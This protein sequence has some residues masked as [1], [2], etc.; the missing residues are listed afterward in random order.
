MLSLLDCIKLEFLLLGK[1]PAN[2]Y[3]GKYKNEN[4]LSFYPTDT[5][6]NPFMR[7]ADYYKLIAN[8][9]FRMWLINE[10]ELIENNL[11][12]IIIMEQKWMKSDWKYN[13]STNTYLYAN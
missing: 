12:I 5:T 2:T 4:T 3:I 13:Y 7:I 6:K 1:A 10:D 8:R 11:L 9:H